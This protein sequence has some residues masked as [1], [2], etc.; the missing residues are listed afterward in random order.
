MWFVSDSDC[1]TFG[2]MVGQRPDAMKE[3]RTSKTSSWEPKP[4]CTNRRIRIYEN[5]QKVSKSMLTA[6][7]GSWSILSDQHQSAAVMSCHCDVIWSGA[8]H[9]SLHKSLWDQSLPRPLQLLAGLQAEGVALVSSAYSEN[10]WEE[11]VSTSET[12]KTKPFK[13]TQQFQDFNSGCAW[14]SWYL[15]ML[16]HHI[17]IE[18]NTKIKVSPAPTWQSDTPDFIWLLPLS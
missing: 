13:N 9:Q 16:R 12:I 2:R 8:A 14:C 10:L 17:H 5:D 6:R 3:R 1:G 15:L 11:E 4:T 7:N 18:T